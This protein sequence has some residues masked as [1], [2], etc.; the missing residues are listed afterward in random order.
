MAARVIGMKCWTHHPRGG[1]TTG[2]ASKRQYAL[3]RWERGIAA[4]EKDAKAGV[5]FTFVPERQLFLGDPPNLTP[6]T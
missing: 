6:V 2:F 5:C 4:T 1:Y 3:E